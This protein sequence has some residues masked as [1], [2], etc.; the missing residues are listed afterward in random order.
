M[1]AHPKDNK[2]VVSLVW[3]NPLSSFVRV[4]E[5]IFA[6]DL[7]NQLIEILS[8]DIAITLY[9]TKNGSIDKLTYRGSTLRYI[10]SR[11]SSGSKGGKWRRNNNIC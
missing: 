5:R 11:F 3:K 9:P 1:N 10:R 4:D 8:K 2:G 6:I 7:N